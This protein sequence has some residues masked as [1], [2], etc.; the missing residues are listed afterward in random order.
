MNRLTRAEVLMLHLLKSHAD[1][2]VML[3]QGW[4]YGQLGTLIGELLG[5]GLVERDSSGAM[6]LSGL[7][8]Q[9]YALHVHRLALGGSAAWI[10]PLD[11]PRQNVLSPDEIYVPS[12]SEVKSL[13]GRRR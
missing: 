12:N 10:A 8:R 9:L 5:K 2:G 11:A 4:N 7:G 6:L 13:D 3:Q 1:L